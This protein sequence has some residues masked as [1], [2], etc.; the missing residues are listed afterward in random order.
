MVKGQGAEEQLH[1]GLHKDTACDTIAGDYTFM[2]TG[3]LRSDLFGIYR[4]DADFS[5]VI[6][7]DFG[8]THGGTATATPTIECASS[9]FP[10]YG[11]LA[12]LAPA[13]YF[14]IRLGRSAHCGLVY[15]ES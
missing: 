5:S 10:V 7:A 4:T 12:R 15:G 3:V 13:P 1:V 14:H 2:N 9:I 6:H 11:V 8:M